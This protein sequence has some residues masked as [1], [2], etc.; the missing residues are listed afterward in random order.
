MHAAA[1]FFVMALLPASDEALS[2]DPTPLGSSIEELA[3]SL[4][5]TPEQHATVADFYAGEAEKA[6]VA[7]KRHERMGRGYVGKQEA[8]GGHCRRLSK[9]FGDLAAEYDEL[10]KYHRQLAT[11]PASP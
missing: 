1:L 2:A 6:R 10:A 8:M 4:A 5:K 11:K 9:M 3:I 7:A